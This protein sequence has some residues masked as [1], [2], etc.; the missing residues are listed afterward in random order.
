LGGREVGAYVG[1]SLGG[2]ATGSMVDGALELETWKLDQENWK[3]SCDPEC[4]HNIGFDTLEGQESTAN[5]AASNPEV[6][7]ILKSVTWQRAK[8]NW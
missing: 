4:E 5:V 7:Q 1:L 3:R 2:I 6:F 8:G